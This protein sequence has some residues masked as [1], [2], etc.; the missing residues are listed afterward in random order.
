MIRGLN[1]FKVTR[2]G[3]APA[4]RARR[5]VDR[6][7][8]AID[9]PLDQAEP[10]A[11][12]ARARRSR[13]DRRGR[14]ARTRAARRRPACRCRCRGP[15]A[16]P[17]VAADDADRRRVPPG[18]VNLNAL[19]SRLSSSR[20]SHSASPLTTTPSA[21]LARAASRPFA[22]ATARPARRPTR[23]AAP[24]STR[25]ARQRD[26]ARLRARQRQQLIDQPLQ[27]VELLELAGRR[28]PRRPGRRPACIA[29]SSIS[30]RSAAIGVRSSCAS[31]VLNWRISPTASSTRASVSLNACATSSSSSCDAAH[32]QPLLQVGDVD[33]ARR[34]GEPRAAGPAR[35]SPSS[36]PRGSPTSRPAGHAPEQQLQEA[37]QRARPWRRA[38]RRPAAGRSR[39]GAPAITLLDRRMRP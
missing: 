22:C 8:V 21:D 16:A 35:P 32:R 12:A 26:L 9:D 17:R 14:T 1:L 33:R 25:C 10:E 36:V 15:P 29:A 39:P 7:V 24:R 11:D 27:L 2:E 37:P 3:R 5:R 31:A 18:G 38:T 23:P 28:A 6:A 19:S 34:G 30:P 20:S 4:R 13:R